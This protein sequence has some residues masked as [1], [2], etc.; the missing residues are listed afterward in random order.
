M[1]SGILNIPTGLKINHRVLVTDRDTKIS[2]EGVVVYTEV[3]LI[4]SAFPCGNKTEYIYVNFDDHTAYSTWLKR[5]SHLISI[6]E[7]GTLDK[8]V[9]REIR[10]ENG[11][12]K[13]LTVGNELRLIP[14]INLCSKEY[15]ILPNKIDSMLVPRLIFNLQ[16]L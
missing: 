7:H 16:S 15:K 8:C 13:E 10:K 12:I 2:Y 9:V 11:K 6:R 3:A 5:G 1:E 14:P 4:N